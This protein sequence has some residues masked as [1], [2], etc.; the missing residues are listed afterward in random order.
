MFVLHRK[1]IWYCQYR[2]EV[3]LS[4]APWFNAELDF[5]DG[6]IKNSFEIESK[7]SEAKLKIE[8]KKDRNHSIFL[9]LFCIDV[10]SSI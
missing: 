2:I 5:Q 8:Y 9:K 6:F 4:F 3:K 1:L 7:K 10:V